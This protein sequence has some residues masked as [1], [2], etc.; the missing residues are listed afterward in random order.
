MPDKHTSLQNEEFCDQVAAEFLA[1]REYLLKEWNIASVGYSSE[2]TIQRI[3]RQI[4]VSRVVI[5]RRLFDFERI[6]R[7]F[8]WKYVNA[9]QEEWQK[10]DKT[11]K[12]RVPY[13]IRIK[14]R[15]GN[16]LINTVI[17][18]ATDGKISE[19]DASRMLNV[20]INNFPRIL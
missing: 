5:A 17:G 19:L 20:K 15:L 16:K 14:S 12:L 6:T 9:C 4:N 11:R 18:A 8:Y 13:K 10:R 2:E 3:S 1:P 7:E